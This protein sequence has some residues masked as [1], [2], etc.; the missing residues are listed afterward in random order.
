MSCLMLALGGAEVGWGTVAVQVEVTVSQCSYFLGTDVPAG[1]AVAVHRDRECWWSQEHRQGETTRVRLLDTLPA[2]G[3]DSH[4]PTCLL[5][6][7]EQKKRVELHTLKLSADF[8]Y[9]HTILSTLLQ[10][11]CHNALAQ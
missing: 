10:L 5:Y 9:L 3:P 11:S 8:S 6:K 1:G 4:S 7:E 2:G